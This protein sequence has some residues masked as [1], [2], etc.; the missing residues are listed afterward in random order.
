LPQMCS[1]LV[2]HF[3]ARTKQQTFY[4][5]RYKRRRMTKLFDIDMTTTTTTTCSAGEGGLMGT[6]V[7][8][9]QARSG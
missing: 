3:A 4:A 8:S 7:L 6:Q 2:F 9:G 5:Q 1:G